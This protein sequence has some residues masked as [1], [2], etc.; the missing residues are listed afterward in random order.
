[1]MLPADAYNTPTPA[2]GFVDMDAALTSSAISITP[3]PAVLISIET[4]NRYCCNQ[5]AV[6]LIMQVSTDGVN[7]ST[8]YDAAD[9]NPPNIFVSNSTKL[10]FNVTS[11]L[12][13]QDTAY[14][15]FYFTGGS[16]YMWMLDDLLIEEGF[17]N[18][19]EL[20]DYS[21]NFSDSYFRNPAFTI[22]PQDMI[23]PLTFDGATVVAGG[24]VQ[25]GV[26]LDAKIYHDSTW[27]GGP[28]D[29]L[30]YQDSTFISNFAT[31]SQRDT[32]RVGPYF[33][34]REG[35]MRARV[36]VVSDSVS[37]NP[38]ATFNEYSFAVSDTVLAK[39]R[40]TFSGDIGVAS[41]VNNGV[42]IGSQGD[43]WTTVITNGPDS[44]LV[45]S[46]SFF[47]SNDAGNLGVQISPIIWE[48]EGDSLIAGTIASAHT[49]LVGENLIPTTITAADTLSWLTIDFASGFGTGNVWLE[50]N[51]QYAIGWR[52]ENGGN[53]EEFFAGRAFNM[54]RFQP[55]LTNFINFAG[56][57]WGWV[58]SQPAIRL[59][60]GN[61]TTGVSD[62]KSQENVSF[63]VAP[64]PTNGEFTLTAKS[65]SATS[66]NLIVRNMLGQTVHSE[67]IAVNGQM[68]KNMNLNSLEKGVYFVSLENDEEKLVKKVVL[69]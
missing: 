69:K 66:Y 51:Q 67:L 2:G 55:D 18:S 30:V 29:W 4:S 45:T 22:V 62:V 41:Y 35:Y 64:N 56:N 26:Y 9:G 7:W 24:N 23:N 6:D 63:A 65:N 32:V 15:R 53:G 60:M 39:D 52:Q 13:Y 58:T 54:E 37:Q 3:S 38:S 50:P 34:I 33:N 43:M 20:E 44:V 59:N 16:H 19:M 31:P 17:E 27:T 12:A 48:F 47:V 5:G 11:E 40:N 42:A 1:M 49:N 57:T 61:L 10:T 8:G 28:G 14:V 25:T 68:T 36:S 21:V 46:L